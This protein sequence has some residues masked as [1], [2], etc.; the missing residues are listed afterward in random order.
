EPNLAGPVDASYRLGPGDRLVLVLTGDIEAAY[1]LDITREGFVVVP[2]VGQLYVANLTMADAERMFQQRLARSYS[3]IGSTTR[4][5]LSVASLRSN[6]VFVLGDVTRPG[7]Y[8]ISAAG[9]ALTALYAAG[10]PTDN[11]SL[12][13]IIVRRGGQTVA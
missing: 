4:F 6:Q 9:T 12:R 2:Q 7:S 3:G 1:P 8:R 5:S 10:G 11:G 13:E